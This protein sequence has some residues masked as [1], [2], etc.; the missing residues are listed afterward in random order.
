MS[1]VL[2]SALSGG[3]YIYMYI[4]KTASLNSENAP[5][6]FLIAISLVILNMIITIAVLRRANKFL[7]ESGHEYEAESSGLKKGVITL[8]AFALVLAACAGFD[9]YRLTRKAEIEPY[10]TADIAMDADER[11]RIENAL[12]DYGVD[13]EVLKLLPNSEIM[14]FRN[15]ASIDKLTDMSLQGIKYTKEYQSRR[16][17]D[18][19]LQSGVYTM[20]TTGDP[21]YYFENLTYCVCLLYTS[22][23][24][25]DA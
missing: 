21:S 14:R 18:G 2:L 15:T 6:F 23:S 5:I 17:S 22:P 9:A 19:K 11:A 10:S 3:T 16:N 12:A 4:T 13:R 25:R 8:C 24:P 20:G 7:Y 1:N